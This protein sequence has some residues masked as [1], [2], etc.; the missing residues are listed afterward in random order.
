MADVKISQMGQQ[1]AGLPFYEA[2]LSTTSKKYVIGCDGNGVMVVK[3]RAWLNNLG[4]STT[5][6]NTF[7][8]GAD[9][10]IRSALNLNASNATNLDSRFPVATLPAG[11]QVVTGYDRTTGWASTYPKDTI[12]TTWGAVGTGGSGGTG[13]GGSGTGGTGSSGSGSG[14]TGSGGNDDKITYQ[15]ATIGEQITTFLSNYWWVVVILALL[16]LWNPV[17]APA[18]GMGKKRKRSYR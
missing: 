11:F 13:N 12:T 16:L 3:T 9:A 5:L 1:A 15:A 10:D 6:Q 8:D 14:G 18:L 4:Y 7:E 17:I 2:V